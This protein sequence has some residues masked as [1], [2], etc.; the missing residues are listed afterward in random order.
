MTNQQISSPRIFVELGLASPLMLLAPV[1]LALP[2]L[3]WGFD[4]NWAAV[5]IGAAGWLI[6]LVIRMPVALLAKQFLGSPA[7]IQRTIV[8]ASGPAEETVRLGVLLIVGT[9]FEVAYSIGL[10]WAAIEVVY[11]I[12]NGFVIL[13]LLS[14][15]DEKANEAREQLAELGI[16]TDVSPFWGIL[17]RLSASMV[18]V[19]LTLL[20]ARW[21]FLVI[22]AIPLHSV[23]N[24]TVLA[25]NKHSAIFAQGVVAIFGV[26]LFMAGL[27]AFGQL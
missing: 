13:S 10:G 20:V 12:V 18:H 7:A 19:A 16:G 9:Q 1:L 17:E 2:L 15:D 24:V 25:A 22:A 5:G 27:A 6:A 21:P 4:L 8:Y 11:A 3:E 26:V 23:M 14:R